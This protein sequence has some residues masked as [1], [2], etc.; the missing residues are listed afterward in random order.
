MEIKNILV[1]GSGQMGKGIAQVALEAGFNVAVRDVDEAQLQRAR[2]DISF[3]LERK[4]QKGGLERAALETLLGRLS[5]S[6]DWG[7]AADA[8]VVIEAITEHEETKRCLFQELDRL[9]P[10]RTVLASNTSAIPISKL[11]AATARPQQVIGM[12]FSNPAPVMRLLE[13]IPGCLT[14]P[15]T[16]EIAKDLGRRFGKEVVE[17][18]DYPGFLT[19]RL[20][21]PIVNDAI[22]ALYNGLG[23]AKDIDTSFRLGLNHPMGPLELADFIGLDTILSIL[24]TLHEGH[25]DARYFP[26][27]LLVQMVEAGLLGRKSGRGFYQYASE[28][29]V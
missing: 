9:C 7:P 8:D 5:L 1:V 26:C 22:Y 28:E 10:E 2:R 19:T 11:G 27:P 24:R 17:A 23:S 29:K 20:G 15:Q 21:M 25:G 3:Q 4:V 6:A 16:V 12:H 14:S 13:V 18:K